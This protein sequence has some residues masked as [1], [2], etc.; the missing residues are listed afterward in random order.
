MQDFVHQP[1]VTALN[2]GVNASDKNLDTYIKA[3]IHP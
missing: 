1:Y 2:S 3:R